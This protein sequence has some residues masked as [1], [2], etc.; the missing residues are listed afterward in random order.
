MSTILLQNE[1]VRIL[2]PSLVSLLNKTQSILIQQ[3]HFLTEQGLGI[4]YE[5]KTWIY[6]TATQWGKELMVCERQA[7]RVISTLKKLGIIQVS[8]L[9]KNKSNRTNYI[10]LDYKVLHEFLISEG[11]SREIND[12]AEEDQYK[13]KMSGSARQNVRMV[14]QR[15][16]TKIK[17][18]KLIKLIDKNDSEKILVREEEG[19]LEGKNTCYEKL[20]PEKNKRVPKTTITQDMLAVWNNAFPKAKTTMSKELAPLLVATF[21]RLDSNL[22]RWKHYCDLISSSSYLQGERFSLSLQWATKFSIMDR[23]FKGEFGVSKPQLEYILPMKLRTES[24]K[25]HIK[26]LVGIEDEIC[27]KLRNWF[28]ERYGADSYKSWLQ[29]A[30]IR[31]ENKAVFIENTS[32]WRKQY[33]MNNF[34][35]T[36]GW[37]KIAEAKIEIA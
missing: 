12:I 29:L 36:S 13:D 19:L 17:E 22:D 7:T 4:V 8:K 20:L 16:L 37:K 18:D 31:H 3:L 30:S 35:L 28:L 27:I 15:K 1:G 26:S 11:S 24:A 6:N 32:T 34:F 25:N 14:I 33:M 10:S 21:K 5:G 23:I 9:S 2:Q